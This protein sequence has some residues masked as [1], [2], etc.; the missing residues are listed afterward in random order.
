MNALLAKAEHAKWL[1]LCAQLQRLGAVTAADL[2][3]SASGP[4]VTDGQRL[5]QLV[6]EWADLHAELHGA[7]L[8]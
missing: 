1:T 2:S 8:P 6:K 7:V 5:L 4:H 3:A